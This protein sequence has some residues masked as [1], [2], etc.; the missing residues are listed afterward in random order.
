MNELIPPTQDRVR[1]NT[2]RAVNSNIDTRI[3]ENIRVY[4][5]QSNQ[6]ISEHI[7]ELNKEWDI[8]RLLERNASTIVIIG[9]ILGAFV[10]Q[11]FLLIPGLVGVFLLQHALQGWCPPLPIFRRMGKRTRNEIDM[12]KFAMKALRGDFDQLETIRDRISRAN[13]VI[14]AVRD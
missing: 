5:T 3:A 7:R 4:S 1:D 8:E 11:W 6:A 9:T 14:D 2:A 13:C 10:N 12:E